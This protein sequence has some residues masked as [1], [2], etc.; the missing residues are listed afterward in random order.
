MFVC[1]QSNNQWATFKKIKT[2]FS[3]DFS[4]DDYDDDFGRRLSERSEQSERRQRASASARKKC[5]ESECGV[6]RGRRRR[7]VRAAGQVGGAP[8]LGARGR[9]SRS[10]GHHCRARHGLHLHHR[11][12]GALHQGEATLF[13]SSMRRTRVSGLENPVSENIFKKNWFTS[14]CSPSLFSSLVQR[15]SFS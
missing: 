13:P 4:D 8:P 1:F 5:E 12:P 11:A 15:Q 3:S 2:L 10:G 9:R 14:H 6:A 7:R